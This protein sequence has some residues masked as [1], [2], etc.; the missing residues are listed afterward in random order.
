MVLEWNGYVLNTTLIS[1]IYIIYCQT[2]VSQYQRVI[3]YLK[4]KKIG[5]QSQK[6][7]PR[8]LMHRDFDNDE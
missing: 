3:D 5:Y 2:K 4:R 8:D 1:Q 7:F 6:I